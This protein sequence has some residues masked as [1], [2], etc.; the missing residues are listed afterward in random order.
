MGFYENG[1]ERTAAICVGATS[2]AFGALPSG[3][4]ETGVGLAG[5][6]GFVLG[7]SQKFGPECARVRNRIRKKVLEDYDAYIKAEGDNWD[8]NADL[9][10]A[11]E[12]LQECLGECV[13]DRKKLAA[14][15]VTPKGFPQQAV[16]VIMDGL[17][18]VRPDL[19]GEGRKED[20]PYRY[21][22]DVVRAGIEET[23]GNS[24]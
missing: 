24:Q 8:L 14:S 2:L 7:K 23:V 17:A 15:A 9:Q 22:T 12:A 18:E 5:V 10:S 21:A 1:L 11:D 3:V 19:F 16:I 6:A 13:I 4:L 20:L